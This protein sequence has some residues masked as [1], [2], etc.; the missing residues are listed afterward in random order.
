MHVQIRVL[1]NIN[2]KMF[3]NYE[4]YSL[5]ILINQSLAEGVF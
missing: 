4:N 5:V 2:K 3:T 1:F